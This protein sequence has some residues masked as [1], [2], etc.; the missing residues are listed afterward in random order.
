MHLRIEFFGGRFDGQ[1]LAT[2]CIADDCD[3]AALLL[4][5]RDCGSAGKQ[6][7]LISPKGSELIQSVGIEEGLVSEWP[8]RT[9]RNRKWRSLPCGFFMRQLPLHLP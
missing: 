4:H 7:C 2:D 5:V 1:V 6:F 9:Q 8:V 3:F